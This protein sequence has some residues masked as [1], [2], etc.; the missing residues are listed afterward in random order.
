M[1]APDSDAKRVVDL[2]ERGRRGESPPGSATEARPDEY[3]LNDLI[4][5][6]IE[7]H[8]FPVPGT[9]IAVFMA[10]WALELMPETKRMGTV[11][12][13]WLCLPSGIHTVLRHRLGKTQFRVRDL[14]KIACT[15]Y[16]KDTGLGYRI[17]LDTR[18][19]PEFP[20]IDHWFRRL[21]DHSVPKGERW[22]PVS[23]QV[24]EARRKVLTATPIRMTT[25][26]LGIETP[27]IACDQ[28]EELFLSTGG[29]TC[30]SCE[31]GH[32][33]EPRDLDETG[34]SPS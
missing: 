19:T 8:G 34:R 32:Y 27:V 18:R 4:R 28:C 1:T 11:I 29:T 15:F 2:I 5:L 6:A 33:Y 25:R 16:D 26:E 7:F 30:R 23:L 12:E 14:H 17:H 20:A 21:L 13:S 22:A 3:T 24:L 10:D 31:V 9:L